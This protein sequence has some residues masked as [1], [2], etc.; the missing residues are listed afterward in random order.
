MSVHPLLLAGGCIALA[1][2]LVR[3]QT[4][5]R[6][7]APRKNG[8]SYRVKLSKS[9]RSV[10]DLD[11]DQWRLSVGLSVDGDYVVGNTEAMRLLMGAYDDR[12]DPDAGF[13]SS[14]AEKRASRSAIKKIRAALQA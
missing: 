3:L 10:L 8:A 5:N 6:R 1:S 14:A 7:R 2:L 12:I 11:D 13:D 4:P 9:E